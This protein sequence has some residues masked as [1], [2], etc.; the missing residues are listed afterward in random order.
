MRPAAGART[1][2]KMRAACLALL[3]TFVLAAAGCGSEDVG[4][5]QATAAQEL[6]QGALVYWELNSDPGSDQWDQAEE[7]IRRFPDGAKWIAKLKDEAEREGDVSWQDDVKP[8]LGDR[9]A[10]ALYATSTDDAN[11]V[12]LT[13]PDDPAKT[14]ALAKKLDEADTG[15]PTV[16]RRVGDWVL[17][18]ESAGDIELA[19]KGESPALADADAFKRAMEELPDDAASR[20]YF[21]ASRLVDLVGAQSPEVTKALERLGLGQLDFAGAWA[22]ARDDG[23]ELGGIVSGEGADRLLGGGDPYASKLL[24]RVPADAFAFYSIQG[25]SIAPQLESLRDNPLYGMALGGFERSLGVRLEDIA[26]LLDGEVALYAAPGAPI[27]EITLLLESDDPDQDRESIA[28]LLRA[29]AASSGG[30]VTE[31]GGVTTA[32]FDGFALNAGSG[33]GMV[34]ISTSTDAFEAVE[35]SL[36]DSEEFKDA[37]EKAETPDR[38][39]GLL[40]TDLS[41]A[42]KLVLGFAQAA[43]ESAPPEVSRNLEPLG[44]LV[45]YGTQDGSLASS[46]AFLEIQ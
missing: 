27:P 12:G 17:I 37:L 10:V 19:L 7:L 31:S 4:L 41:E 43:G 26:A 29:I 21:D 46:L 16:T 25:G 8:A 45:V 1:M 3:S 2:G 24:D 44:S 18:G 32:T 14:E 28:R 23:A 39:T 36:G 35:D 5:G 15:E 33:E 13:N 22:K 6:K 38:Y 9:I 20:L 11:I 34:G 42:A 40:W 30:E